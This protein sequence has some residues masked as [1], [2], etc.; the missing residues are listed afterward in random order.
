MS[1][2]PLVPGSL[3]RLRL[4][5]ALFPE[6]S[7]WSAALAVALL[8]S[9]LIYQLVTLALVPEVPLLFF[10]LFA[11]L[12][13]YRAL[14]SG[15]LVHWLGVGIGFGLAGLSKYTAVTLVISALLLLVWERRWAVLRTPGPWLAAFIALLLI[16]PVLYWNLQHDN[17]LNYVRTGK[18]ANEGWLWRKFTRNR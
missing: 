15:R 18:V 6:A 16:V 1:T 7:A 2:V 17:I 12:M 10:A 14:Q 3:E 13:L 11:A 5:R 4:S 9:A 8:N